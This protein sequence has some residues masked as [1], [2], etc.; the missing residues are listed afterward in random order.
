M[1][2][3]VPYDAD[4]NRTT[5]HH[6]NLYFGASIQALYTLARSKGYEYI[7]CTKAGNDAFFVKKEYAKK[8]I[9]ELITT[10][11]ETFNEQ[12]AKESRDEKGNLTYIRASKR[13]DIIKDMNI[14]DLETNDEVKLH[15]LKEEL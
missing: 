1:K 7:G 3:T 11:L 2:L 13:L 6:S 12:K 5:K 15:T 4:F 10:P 9:K 8:Y 14:I